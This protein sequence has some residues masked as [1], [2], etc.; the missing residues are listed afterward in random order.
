MKI[1]YNKDSSGVVNAA[2]V[3]PLTVCRVV[4]NNSNRGW[5]GAIIMTVKNS[6]GHKGI[7]LLQEVENLSLSCVGVVY[8]ITSDTNV[9]VVVLD[10]TLEINDV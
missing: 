7:V 4:K 8:T 10:S 9:Q 2:N 3:P 5:D 6:D 1:V